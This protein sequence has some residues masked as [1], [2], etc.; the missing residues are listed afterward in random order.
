MN[1]IF[2]AGGALPTNHPSYIERQADRDALRTALNG[3]Y[4]HVIAPRQVGKTSLLK[5][6]AAR[7]TDM[8]W[9]CALVDLSM[10]MDFPKLSWYAE[11]G[12]E[13]A[14]SLTPEHV[15][16][17][18]NQI[19][20]RR[21]LLNNALPWT[22]GQPRIALLFDEVEGAGKARDADGTPFS[23]TFFMT[24]RNLYIQRDDYKGTLIVALAGAVNP[25][26]LVKDPDIS[27]FNVGEEISLDDFTSAE[28][29][30]LTT[31]LTAL[32]RHVDPIVHQVIYDWTNGHP[33]L[34]QRICF[35]L[36]KA[37]S[38]AIAITPERIDHIVEQIIL[39][40]THPIQRDKNLRHVAK[41]LAELSEPARQL[42]SQM[43]AG[44]VVPLRKA[45]DDVYLELYLT[46]AI[47]LQAGHL[48]I[49]N[50]IYAKAF[51]ERDRP[52]MSK[53][54][55]W[56]SAQKVRIAL[57]YRRTRTAHCPFD[58]AILHVLDAGTFGNPYAIMVDCPICRNSFT[59]N[60]IEDLM[61]TEAVQSRN[62]SPALNLRLQHLAD[63][64]HQDLGLLKEY[65]DASRYEDDPRRR[66]KNRREIE[67]LRESAARYQQEYNEL[68]AQ[69]IG[70]PSPVM[71][72]VATQLQQMDDKLDTLL[73][74]Q[75]TIRDDLS[76]LRQAIL[77]RFEANE[78]TLVTALVTQL[79]QVQLTTVQS[80][81]NAIETE[82][83][84]LSQLQDTLTALQQILSEIQQ[85]DII[86]GD[87]TITDE[88]EQVTETVAAPQLDVKHRLMLTLP[89]IPLILSYEGELELNSGLNL[90]AAWQRLVAMAQG[91]LT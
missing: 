32:N 43:Q 1:S 69:V 28:S 42:W 85:D 68:S 24:L 39:N 46:G 31:H 60:E 59:S 22:N 71:Q 54:N 55:T 37:A 30:I 83:F 47:T 40:P 4:L 38:G 41:M 16:T 86:L 63:N 91:K 21:Y 58:G 20:F 15:P 65:E 75:T 35:E 61:E 44:A 23:D 72:D 27:P 70:E 57:T 10:L 76:D 36:E 11:L 13:L 81:L 25:S 66:A 48:V 19:D 12:K 78:Q 18:A 82:R 26:D 88:L 79:D 17:L 9:R 50:P 67:Q 6:L 84:P 87:P 56:T 49:R 34:T 2:Q 73:A 89:I 64:I 77:A 29:Q 45:S 7:L 90:E 33:Y 3:D 51:M 14:Q 5:R 52:M 8:G 62:V 53:T 74:G 80:V